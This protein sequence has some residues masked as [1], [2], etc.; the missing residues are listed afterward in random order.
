MKTTALAIAVACLLGIGG[1]VAVRSAE[2]A[3]VTLSGEVVDLHC[4]LTRGA[5]GTEHAG[6][7][8]ALPRPRRH[9][10]FPRRRWHACSSSLVAVPSP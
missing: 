5:S 1:P 6:C 2:T 4:Y 7:G 8:N 10:G 3:D 9:R